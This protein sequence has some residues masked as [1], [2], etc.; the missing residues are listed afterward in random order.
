M[1][2][3]IKAA[4]YWKF[5]WWKPR[6]GRTE[7]ALAD[8]K[9]Q[10]AEIVEGIKVPELDALSPAALGGC[11]RFKHDLKD[12]LA[13]LGLNAPT[14]S[15]DDILASQKFHPSIEKALLAS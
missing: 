5:W 13:R 2:W 4:R 8:M 9:R 3:S 15:L 12:Y 10:G 11:N 7:A 1:R 6:G 14:K